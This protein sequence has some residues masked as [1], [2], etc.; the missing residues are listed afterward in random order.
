MQ[1]PASILEL[2]LQQNRYAI[3][4]KNDFGV[5]QGDR[6]NSALGLQK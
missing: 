5:H 3:I 6:M 1:L 2:F 4:Y